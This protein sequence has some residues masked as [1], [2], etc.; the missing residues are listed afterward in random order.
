[1]K[2]K[3]EIW[4]VLE[5]RFQ[6]NRIRV[7]SG[8]IA[9]LAQTYTAGRSQL[10]E[11]TQEDVGDEE[12]FSPDSGAGWYVEVNETSDPEFVGELGDDVTEIQFAA[13]QCIS[14]D[15]CPH[16]YLLCT[17]E[18]AAKVVRDDPGRVNFKTSDLKSELE[19]YG[20]EF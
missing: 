5:G 10:Y 18:E 3:D 11:V 4:I 14:Q 6:G 15:D 9:E 16:P 17:A 2:N 13:I 19:Q 1:M 20:Y 12:T 8:T 7:Y